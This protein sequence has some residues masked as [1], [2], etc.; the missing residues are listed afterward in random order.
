MTKLSSRITIEP[1]VFEQ[2][3][4]GDENALSLL[5]EKTQPDIRR[6]AKRTCRSGDIDDAVQETL[7]LLYRRV[8]TVKFIGALPS[9]LFTVVRRECIR[10][11]HH[12]DKHD[13]ENI[14][15]YQ[16][17]AVLTR[18][19]EAALRVDLAQAI[20]FLP[21]NYRHVIILRDLAGM[22]VEEIADHLSL[23][24]GSVKAQL[25]RAR[26]KIREYLSL[27]KNE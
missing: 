27:Y 5:L 12:Q 11:M 1:K 9:W 8:G 18:K 17:D 25:H 22:S 2:A 6:Y 4:L 16:D 21:A 3:K 7:L 19:S 23:S 10:M 24:R 14:D 13:S 26:I 20:H 15:D